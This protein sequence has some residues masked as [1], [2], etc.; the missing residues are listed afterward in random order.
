MAAYVSRCKD[1]KTFANAKPFS[2]KDGLKKHKF[3]FY[4][5]LFALCLQIK[6]RSTSQCPPRGL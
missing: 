4:L 5:H 2:E 6:I 3:R 1:S